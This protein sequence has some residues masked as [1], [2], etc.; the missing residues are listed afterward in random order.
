MRAWDNL[1]HEI[2]E[3]LAPGDARIRMPVSPQARKARPELPSHWQARLIEG[4]RA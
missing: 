4:R 3:Q 2:V 1:R